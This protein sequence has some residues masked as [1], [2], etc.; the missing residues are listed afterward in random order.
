MSWAAAVTLGD[1]A[2]ARRWLRYPRDSSGR[3]YAQRLV[4]IPLHSVQIGFPLGDAR[5]AN[6]ALRRDCATEAERRAA[7]LGE[8]A[9]AAADG[10]QALAGGSWPGDAPWAAASLIELALIEPAFRPLT[11]RMIAR[12]DPGMFRV[13]ARAGA[14]DWPPVRDCFVELFRVSGGDTSST[15]AAIRR[16]RAFAALDPPPV[17]REGWGPID[18]RV[19]P[20]LLE[21][22]LEGGRDRGGASRLDALDAIMRDG[23][24]WLTLAAPATPVAA[25]NWAIARLRESQ[26]DYPRALAAIRRRESNYYPAY[27]WTLPAFLRQEGRLAA[28][29]GDTAGA[30][31]A[32]DSYLVLR[33]NPD[34]AVR[35]QHDSVVAERAGLGDR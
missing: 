25:A 4:K 13:A 34:P 1:S 12:N 22:L 35:A 30:V 24:R 6:A 15:R 28:L 23:P 29:A 18:F 33:A 7:W 14:V 32:Y 9:V 11:A 5:W 21:T 10:S 16:L 3:N 31:Q 2:G 17:P 27:L 19:C 8:Q 20:L 26:G